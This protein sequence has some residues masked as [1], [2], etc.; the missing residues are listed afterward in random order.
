[1]GPALRGAANRIDSGK[2]NSTVSFTV[3]AIM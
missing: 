3:N 1:M 2:I